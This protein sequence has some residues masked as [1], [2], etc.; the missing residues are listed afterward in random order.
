[1]IRRQ[2]KKG[3][4]AK[5]KVRTM[6]GWK[7]EVT[8]GSDQLT[9]DPNEVITFFQNDLPLDWKNRGICLRKEL[10]VPLKRRVY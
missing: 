7:G 2:L 4:Q 3:D 5:L 1:V 10:A 8:V 6:G 9:S